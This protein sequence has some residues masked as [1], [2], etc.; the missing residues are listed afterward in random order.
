MAQDGD[1]PRSRGVYSPSRKALRISVGSS[2]L[3]R[4][5]LNGAALEAEP[6]GSSPLARGLQGDR[7]P[8]DECV[9][10]I[11]A[12]AGFTTISD[13][14]K[15]GREDHP[16]S[17]GV[18]SHWRWSPS[19][20]RWDHPRSR[21]VYTGRPG[22]V[23]SSRGIIPARAGFTWAA[24]PARAPGADHP[25]SRGVYP[26]PRCPPTPTGGSSPLARGLLRELRFGLVETGIIPARAGFTM[27]SPFMKLLCR[28]HP[29][30]R[31]VYDRTGAVR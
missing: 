5:L 7:V 19:R 21:G 25:R 16:R 18:Y 20:R 28:D 9:G 27:T 22:P 23:T 26:P 3:A 11:P 29:R 13:R 15:Y 8:V 1:H 4:G 10:I 2:P 31:G 6:M 24:A 30:S 12:R 14:L 17:R